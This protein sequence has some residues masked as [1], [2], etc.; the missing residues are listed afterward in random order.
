MYSVLKKKRNFK[1]RAEISSYRGP[2]FRST[3]DQVQHPSNLPRVQG[4]SSPVVHG[5]QNVKRNGQKPSIKS[6]TQKKKGSPAHLIPKLRSARTTP[7]DPKRFKK[8]EGKWLSWKRPFF[9]LL[10]ARCSRCSR[11]IFP[12]QR[13]NF[14]SHHNHN[15][16]LVFFINQ[17]I[18]NMV[19]E[20]MVC[21][22]TNQ[23]TKKDEGGWSSTPSSGPRRITLWS[24][25]NSITRRSVAAPAAATN[26]GEDET[27]PEKTKRS[28]MAAQISTN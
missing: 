19:P 1:S 9:P 7:E 16:K 3:A 27:M 5:S 14:Q 24:T 17:Q 4:P 22:S 25:A 18:R 12:R 26:D 13:S 2:F 20:K 23:K 6:K 10:S 8:E 11:E 21:G 28:A 15:K